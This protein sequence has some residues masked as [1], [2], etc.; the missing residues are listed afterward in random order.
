M[1]NS[2]IGKVLL[3]S[4]FSLILVSCNSN[5]P[6]E[7]SKH[8]ISRLEGPETEARIKEILSQMTLK[9][10]AGQM[11]NVGLPSV[12]TKG[13]W[14]KRDSAVFDTARF[15]KLIVEYAVGS[16]HNTPGFP[17]TRKDWFR[18]IKTIQDAAMTETRLKIPVLYGIDDIHGANYVLGSTMFPQ[19][20]AL[21]ASWNPEMA[22]S[23]GEVTSY[24]S[25]TASLPWN[26][27]PNTD[28]AV[29]PLW[30]RIGESF[31]EDTYLVSQ[32]TSAYLLGSQHKGLD[33]STSTAV[34]LKHFLGYGAALNGKDR[35]SAT[36]PENYLR[37]YYLPQFEEA[38]NK[39]AMGVMVSS[40]NVNG[41]PCHS[42]YFYITSILKGELGF[43]GVVISD[44]SDIENLVVAHQ[45]AEDKR[46]AT[47]QAVN[48]GLDMIMNPYDADVVDYIVDLVEKGEIPMV[49]IDDAV[50]R[51]LR[52]KFYLNLFEVPY[53]D[54]AN[55]TGFAS[56]ENTEK[57]YQAAGEAV[58]LLKN[59]NNILP[60]PANKRILV[61]GYSANSI[62]VL[63]GAWSRSF[64]GQDTLFNDR[65]KLTILQGIKANSDA[66]KIMY[67]EGTNYLED[68]NTDKALALAR[69][70]DYVVVCLGEIPA[71][72]KPSDINELDMPMVQQELV[73]KLAAI[74][75]PI[76]LVM[77]Q[78]RPRII[79]EIEP[80]CDAVVMGFLPGNE[81][82]RAIADVLFGKI[83]PS[84]KLP[85]TWPKYTG[86]ALVYNHKKSDVRDINWGY[87]GFYPQYE[88]GYGLS[89]TKFE[90]SDL[91][92]SADSLNMGET[93]KISVKVSNTGSL[94]GKEV[95][96]LFTRDIVASIAPD[97]KSLKRFDKIS[98]KPGESKT[99]EFSISDKDL[100][101]VGADNQ[102]ITE[103]GKFQVSIGGGPGNMLS[104]EF[105]LSE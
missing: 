59:S 27:N 11:L 20:I 78:G 73:K 7:S 95:V 41:I 45:T 21:A 72:E 64:L 66:S 104:K 19:E 42:N 31:G 99:V 102:W 9:E 71:S 12:L 53:N 52:L 47:K 33:D 69:N 75:K 76:I 50:T 44:F 61:T 96:E 35:A 92:L 46:E 98:L 22:F 65:D 24:E 103:K 3:L 49:R 87:D 56:A 82:G 101:F 37:Q 14:D 51:I 84:G 6:T 81:G 63:N 100:G 88:F 55:Y 94:E 54:P 77:V 36:I 25:R 43:K 8:K 28:L 86:N 89:F 40:N 15:R 80:L 48:A 1:Q 4:I 32:M 105:Y 83:N 91:H 16:M 18:L 97:V 38:I 60:L 34:C 13:Y 57:N 68:I 17:P 10:K 30:G 23:C 62:N 29:N 85:Y 79:R 67:A 26:Y 2:F 39:G 5:Q 74:K 58:T 70:A 93:L 90:Y